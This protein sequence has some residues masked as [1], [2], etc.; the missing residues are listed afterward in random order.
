MSFQTFLFSM[1]DP[2]SPILI[3]FPIAKNSIKTYCIDF[4]A[5]DIMGFL[6]I[7]CYALTATKKYLK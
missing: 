2:F 1:P 5:A 6:P 7:F 3:K 4:R